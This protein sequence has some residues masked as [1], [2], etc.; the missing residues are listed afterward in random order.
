MF[1]NRV[2][3]FNLWW[4]Y[5]KNTESKEEEAKAALDKL[6]AVGNKKKQHIKKKTSHHSPYVALFD[7]SSRSISRLFIQQQHQTNK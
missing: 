6:P 2:F 4:F 3:D 5:F 7:Y 1:E